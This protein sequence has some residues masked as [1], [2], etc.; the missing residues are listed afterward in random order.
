MCINYQC[1]RGSST[2]LRVADA[3]LWRRELCCLSTERRRGSGQQNSAKLRK[4]NCD[5]PTTIFEGF[6]NFE[7]N[8]MDTMDSQDGLKTISLPLFLNT[9]F[10]FLSPSV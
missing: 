3:E 1:S 9:E 2:V 4:I 8:T 7:I 6:V 5:A 10:N